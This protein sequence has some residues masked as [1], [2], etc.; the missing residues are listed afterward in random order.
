[1]DKL[2]FKSDPGLGSEVKH[3][4]INEDSSKLQLNSKKKQLDNNY[5]M[6]LNLR[7]LRRTWR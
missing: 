4:S 2:V 5:I 3:S 6:L 1:M 7:T